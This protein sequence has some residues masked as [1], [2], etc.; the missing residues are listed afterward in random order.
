MKRL[1]ILFLFVSCNVYEVNAQ[2]ALS[3]YKEK[4]TALFRTTINC[5]QDI[6]V[7]LRDGDF[8]SQIEVCTS[9]HKKN[10][11]TLKPLLR[12]VKKS[13]NLDT[14]KMEKEMIEVG[15]E[16][17]FCGLFRVKGKDKVKDCFIDGTKKLENIIC[18]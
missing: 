15:L 7:D 1:L 3:K 11:K 5:F 4:C 16:M 6:S 14:D 2:T 10:L 12:E 9:T 17:S 8:F 18:F 13:V